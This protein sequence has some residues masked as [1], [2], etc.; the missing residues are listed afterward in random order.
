MASYG[1]IEH[2]WG[3]EQTILSFLYSYA[4]SVLWWPWQRAF[5]G[6]SEDNHGK[7]NKD[8]ANTKQKCSDATVG[9]KG[10]IVE[11]VSNVYAI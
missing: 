7:W 4:N 3:S 9:D 6:R 8:V 5:P 11:S 2:T 1:Y 10:K